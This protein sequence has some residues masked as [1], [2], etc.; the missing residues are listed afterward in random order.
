[1]I[2]EKR[3]LRRLQRHA[4]ADTRR[5]DINNTMEASEN[6]QKMFHKL[7]KAQRNTHTDHTAILREGNNEISDPS[8]ILDTWKFHFELLATPT[9]NSTNKNNIIELPNQLILE[10]E[11]LMGSPIDPATTLEVKN[12]IGNINKNKAADK[13]GI[14]AEHL[15]YATE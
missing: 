14:S 4:H 11:L 2:Q 15:Q 12:A 7:I 13:D 8:E 10:K 9:E 3:N 1:M 5:K 6:D